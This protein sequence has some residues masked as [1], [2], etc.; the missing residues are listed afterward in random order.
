MPKSKTPAGKLEASRM[1]PQRQ[2]AVRL[3]WGEYLKIA[4]LIAA[5][6]ATYWVATGQIIDQMNRRFDS[7][8]NRVTKIEDRLNSVAEG[9]ARI[10]ARLGGSSD[11]N[12]S[13][14]TGASQ[15]GTLPP[16]LGIT[17]WIALNVNNKP[18]SLLSPDGIWSGVW[19]KA[20][21]K[22]TST[23]GAAVK[24]VPAD[25][26]P[27]LLEDLDYAGTIIGENDP[28][29]K[30]LLAKGW[31]EKSLDT[32]FRA[33]GYGPYK[34]SFLVIPRVVRSGNLPKVTAALDSISSN[35]WA[36]LAQDI[37]EGNLPAQ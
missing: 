32:Y 31:Y 36:E 19:V 10:E 30:G 4:G 16:Q 18:Y 28:T 34:Y 17:F 33:T 7:L 27:S 1:S 15:S 14:G 6:I 11:S 20:S 24:F 12:S 29:Y 35:F 21:S 26:A 23:L 22:W 5:I 8:E 37:L 13:G 25:T 9:I 3:A 2:P